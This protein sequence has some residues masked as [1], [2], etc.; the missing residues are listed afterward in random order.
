M[1]RPTVK[2]SGL[3]FFAIIFLLAFSG[4][5]QTDSMPP[6][7]TL[8]LNVL[9]SMG[10]SYMEKAVSA[11]VKDSLELRGYNVTVIDNKTLAGQDR[12][13]YRMVILFS[14]IKANRLTRTA[15]KF[16]RSQSGFGEESNLLICDILGQKWQPSRQSLDAVATATMR[17]RPEETASRILANF[18]SLA[19]RK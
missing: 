5:G 15:E 7:D 8:P 19:A 12:R 11:I 1:V 10:S 9:I 17:I 18:D 16:V 14:A 6:G 13:L 3:A 4:L 2:T